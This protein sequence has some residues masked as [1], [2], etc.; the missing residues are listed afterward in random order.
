MP[1]GAPGRRCPCFLPRTRGTEAARGRHLH[2]RGCAGT[3]TFPTEKRVLSWQRRVV[4]GS[5]HIAPGEH[6][7]RQVG[8]Y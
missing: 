8:E 5:P 3:W 1:K 6:F 7:Q 2:P 4:D